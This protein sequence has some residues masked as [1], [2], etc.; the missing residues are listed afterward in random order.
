M[1]T[2]KA[3]MD[4]F[5]VNALVMGGVTAIMKVGSVLWSGLCGRSLGSSSLLSSTSIHPLAHLQNP[6]ILF[7]NS[8]L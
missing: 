2:N 5:I 7:G 4:I 3:I 6:R 1:G 8:T